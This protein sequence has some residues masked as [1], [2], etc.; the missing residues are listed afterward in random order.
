MVHE[1]IRYRIAHDL[2]SS[3][4]S[5]YAQA[6][7]VLRASAVCLGYGLSQCEEDP[8]CFILRIDWTS[9]SDHLQNFRRSADFATFFRA[10]RPYVDQIEEMRHYRL[11]ELAWTR[12]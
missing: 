4:L 9:T 3:F 5:D 2:Q 6:G 7:T 11:T 1:Y 10:I 8:E 12:E